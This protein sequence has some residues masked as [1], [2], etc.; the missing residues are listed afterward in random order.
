MSETL[1][2]PGCGKSASG[3]FC[4]SCGTPLGGRFCN[5][6]GAKVDSGAAFCS[7]CGAGMNGAAAPGSAGKRAAAG[8]GAGGG[9]KTGGGARAGSKGG[10]GTPRQGAQAAGSSG[11][12]VGNM[13]W[14][15][16][17]AMM[18]VVMFFMIRPI[19][20]P[21]DPAQSVPSPFAG[22]GGAPAGQ[23]AVTDISNMSPREAAIRLF[24]RVMTAAEQN[25][26]GEV[27]MFLPMAI[28]AYQLI[29]TLDPVTHYHL[30]RLQLMAT[31]SQDALGTAQ[32]GLELNGDHLLNLYAAGDAAL[33]L[34]DTAMAREY[35]GKILQV[36]DAQMASG[37]VDYQ[38]HAG[39]MDAIRQYAEANAGG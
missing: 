26:D 29:D 2:C 7:E 3:N 4:A 17:A 25:N 8:A 27:T 23:R 14:W 16:A 1:T 19:I 34:G 10:T 15:L 35:F 11:E 39:Q 24:N 22:A 21:E 5:Q 13:G 9:S 38:A 20:W 36:W 30:S 12:G 18:V 37:N 6:C 28:Q 33:T 32:A 31:F